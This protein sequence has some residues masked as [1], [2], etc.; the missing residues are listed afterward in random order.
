MKG[1][2][3][4]CLVSSQEGSQIDLRAPRFAPKNKPISTNLV[5]DQMK[6]TRPI[7]KKSKAP[8]PNPPLSNSPHP[9][10]RISPT[11]SPNIQPP[12]SYL[13]VKKNSAPKYPDHRPTHLTNPN[14]HLPDHPSP[15]T[16]NRPRNFSIQLDRMKTPAHEPWKEIRPDGPKLSHR[17]EHLSF[18]YN[19]NLWVHGG[20]DFNKGV[21]NDLFYLEMDQTESNYQWIAVVSDAKQT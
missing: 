10:R 19:K 13:Y 5:K 14:P 11:A 15:T 12:T 8:H 17:T 18:A 6:P 4:F 21:M 16:P 3:P 1:V 2:P 7:P 9:P 20:L